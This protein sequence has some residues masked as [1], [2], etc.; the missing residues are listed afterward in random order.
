MIRILLPAYYPY[1]YAGRRQCDNS[2]SGGV[3]ARKR[4]EAE[5]CAAYNIGAPREMQQ[6][7]R[8][9]VISYDRVPVVMD[10]FPPKSYYVR[11]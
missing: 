4:N 6:P 7:T 3:V 1:V 5:G 10:C 2:T 11:V 8:L 9:L